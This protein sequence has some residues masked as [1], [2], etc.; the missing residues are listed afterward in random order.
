MKK[1]QTWRAGI[2]PYRYT[3]DGKI[4][5]LFMQPSNPRYGGDKFQIAKGKIEPGESPEEAAKREV[6]EELGLTPNQFKDMHYLGLYMGRTHLYTAE[7]IED[8]LQTECCDETGATKWMT[9]DEFASHGRN[10]HVSIVCD[11][12]KSLNKNS[13]KHI[14]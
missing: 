4:R 7:V 8:F 9:V 2:I 10:L 13:R 5:M 14:I 6:M 3:D 11:A 12:V 1:K